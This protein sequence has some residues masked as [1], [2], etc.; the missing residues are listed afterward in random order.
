MCRGEG[1]TRPHPCFPLLSPKKPKVLNMGRKSFSSVKGKTYGKYARKANWSYATRKE[2]VRSFVP[3]TMGPLAQTEHKYF[4]TF[5]DVTAITAPTAWTGT[6]L[7]PATIGCLFAPTQ[8]AGI[9]DR[10]GRKVQVKAIRIKGMIHCAA[11]ADQTAGDAA[12]VVRLVLVQDHQPNG[13]QVQGEDIM[14]APGGAS[15][16]LVPFSFQNLSNLGRFRVLK[17]KIFTLQNPNAVW[18]GTNIE[19]QG[20]AKPFKWNIKFQKPIEVH[21]NATNGGTYADLVN[22]NFTII[23]AATSTNLAPTLTYTC[24]VMFCDP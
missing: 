1:N 6:E 7:N 15:A 18:D 12:S 24:R 19:Q 16:T 17:D 20:V 14:A 21:F 5:L 22:C 3:R 2:P 10:V 4:D 8:G 11:Q 23:G 9:S 13:T